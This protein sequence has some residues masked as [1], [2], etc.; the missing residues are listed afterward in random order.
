MVDGEPFSVNG[1]LS[2]P[3]PAFEPNEE[4]WDGNFLISAICKL[5]K[6]KTRVR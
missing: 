1:T 5:G 4:K 3:E 2:A 6:G